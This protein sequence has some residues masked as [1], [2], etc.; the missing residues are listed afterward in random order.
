VPTLLVRPVTIARRLARGALALPALL[1]ACAP[2]VDIA[3]VPSPASV[4]GVDTR[5][6]AHLG[7][8]ALMVMLDDAEQAAQRAGA[9]GNRATWVALGDDFADGVLE[10]DVAATLTG[11]GGPDSRGFVGLAWHIADDRDA[12]EA[13]YLR[14]TNGTRNVPPPPSP[15]DTRAVQYIAHPAFHFGVSRER[16][17]GRYEQAAPVA[18]GSWHRLRVDVAGARV[19]AHVDGVRVLEIDD[20][21]RTAPRGRWGIWVGDGTAAYV[22]NV[23]VTRRR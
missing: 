7:R 1:V 8:P 6:A 12:F 10:A 9:G 5:I 11:R 2:P 16:A 20:A 14:M 23:R 17:P 3:R 22:A 13:V 15:R 4:R 21:R 19:I 18:L